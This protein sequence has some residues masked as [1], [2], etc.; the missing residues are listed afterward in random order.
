MSTKKKL[1]HSSQ[2]IID[3]F[4]PEDIEDGDVAQGRRAKLLVF[5]SLFL[6]PV[7]AFFAFGNLFLWGIPY[8]A[9]AFAITCPCFFSLLFLFKKTGNILLTSC[10]LI[11]IGLCLLT[12][13]SWFS[14][15]IFASTLCWFA[16]PTLLGSL[17]S[18]RRMGGIWLILSFICIG[19]LL[20]F[21]PTRD[22]ILSGLVT[23]RG[24][25]E[26]FLS[27]SVLLIV[28]FVFS[29]TYE[30]IT[31]EELAKRERLN[32][33]LIQAK[34]LAEIS[35]VNKGNFLAKM[36][37]ELRTP[38]HG[39]TS[40]LELMKLDKNTEQKDQN[41]QILLRNTQV[42]Q[43][44]LSDLLNFHLLETDRVKIVSK[45]F[46]LQAFLK[47]FEIQSRILVENKQLQFSFE[48]IGSSTPRLLGD[49][50]RFS[51]VLFNLL[52]NSIKFTESGEVSITIDTAIVST[53]HQEITFTIKDT[54]I[55]IA[56]HNLENIFEQ[57]HQVDNSYAR[58][59]EGIGLGLAISRNLIDRMGGKIEV[60]SILGKGTTFTVTICFEISTLDSPSELLQ[61]RNFTTPQRILVVDDNKLNREVLV[62]MLSTIGFSAKSTASGKEALTL[63]SENFQTV[64]FDI[65]MPEMDG[66][67]LTK[68]W[69]ELET[70]QSQ[71]IIVTADIHPEQM[72]RCTAA[73]ID[74]I[75]SKPFSINELKQVMN[76]TNQFE[77][78]N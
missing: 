26:F 77:T 62:E 30:K 32:L 8:S 49:Q 27:V 61:P 60:S 68:L 41:I 58:K 3:Y 46:S 12:I 13:D 74:Y 4:I 50:N 51:Q 66:V 48:I 1:K 21:G 22:D 19:I 35:N 23:L 29:L 75:L 56:N 5:I 6:T 44:I 42:F 31:E 78:S 59:H 14:G 34:D 57:F 18:G 15:G 43:H 36:S 9:I 54:G 28:V 39:I 52:D 7:T 63:I 17:L 73:G 11:G 2:S 40:I 37:H 71:I 53:T 16:L 72:K 10:F 65:H 38:L 24:I 64:F 20:I 47:D 76:Q 25:D 55:G 67:E 45:P 69:R 33:E 70:I